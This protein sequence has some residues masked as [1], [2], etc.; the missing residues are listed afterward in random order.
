MLDGQLQ[1]LRYAR[2]AGQALAMASTAGRIN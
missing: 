1:A 2:G